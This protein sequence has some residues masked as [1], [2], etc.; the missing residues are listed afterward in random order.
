M[1]DHEFDNYLALLSRLLR[2]DRKQRDAIAGELRA[3]LEDRLDELL[4][5]GVPRDEAVR[6]A[7]EEF[8]DAAGLAAEFV[9]LSGNKRKRW[10]MR[11]TTASAAAIVLISAGIFT[12]WPGNNAGPGAAQV[13]AQAPTGAAAADPNSEKP[14]DKGKDASI[15]EVLE[16]RMAFEFEEVPLKDVARK[17]SEQTGITIVLDAKHLEEAEVN[18]DTPITQN[19]RDVRLRTFLDLMLGD[20]ELAHLVTDDV[21]VITTREH[22]DA[23]RL[24]RVYDCR[25]L[26][27]MVRPR[28]S[29]LPKVMRGGMGGGFFAVQDQAVQKTPP[30]SASDDDAAAPA[31]GR[32]T[33]PTGQNG[34]GAG[35]VGGG[36]FAEGN[37]GTEM[38]DAENLIQFITTIVDPEI[39]SDAGGP[40]AIAEYKGLVSVASTQATHEKVE[41]LLNMLH[42]AANLKETKVTVVE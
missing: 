1:S 27:A 29:V 23:W 40:S 36:R 33:A 16:R 9:S 24:I 19:F 31:N 12:F 21:L 39:W 26:L 6:Q 35:Q 42:Q 18:I 17:L 41:R 3:H 4:A 34:S 32:A 7:L 14:G 28:G 2:L 10:I 37:A 20:L 30:A 5:R 38:S 15:K 25:E 8:G 11:L 22:A 13:V